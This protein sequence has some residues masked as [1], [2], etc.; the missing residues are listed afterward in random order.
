VVVLTG[1]RASKGLIEFA[2]TV[3]EMLCVKH[4]YAQG[5]KAQAGVEF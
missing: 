1:R 2:D 4:G 5:R 3:T